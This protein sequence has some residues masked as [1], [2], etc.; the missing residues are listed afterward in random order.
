MRADPPYLLDLRNDGS[1][2]MNVA[3]LKQ[4]IEW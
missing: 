4:P 2:R 3:K 1:I